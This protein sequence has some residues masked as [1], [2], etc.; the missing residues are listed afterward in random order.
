MADAL[1]A[2]DDLMDNWIETELEIRRKTELT[3][4]RGCCGWGQGQ[5]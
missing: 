1:N 3:E 2:L 5:D 4:L